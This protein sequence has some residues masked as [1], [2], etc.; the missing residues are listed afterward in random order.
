MNVR[1][2]D[3]NGPG[4]RYYCTI[5]VYDVAEREWQ[6]VML[7]GTP[8]SILGEIRW[9]WAQGWDAQFGGEAGH[10]RGEFEVGGLTVEQVESRCEAIMLAVQAAT[11]KHH[12]GFHFLCDPTITP[13]SLSYGWMADDGCKGCGRSQSDRN[14][15]FDEDGWCPRC[16]RMFKQSWIRRHKGKDQQP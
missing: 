13:R 7:A 6:A 2:D 3:L 16:A 11:G 4:Q 15:E 5:L 14:L 12:K 8:D 10:M 9:N 1:T